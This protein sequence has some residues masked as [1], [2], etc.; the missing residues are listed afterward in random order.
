MK[1]RLGVRTSLDARATDG[2]MDGWARARVIRGF[3][4]RGERR[5]RTA[6]VRRGRFTTREARTRE[7]TNERTNERTI[8]FDSI[9]LI[10]FGKRCSRVLASERREDARAAREARSGRW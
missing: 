10:G 2:T 5:R 7:R 3:A 6:T 9:R 1:S 4:R 8:R